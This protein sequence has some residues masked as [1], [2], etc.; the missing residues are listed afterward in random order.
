MREV[1]ILVVEHHPITRWGLVTLIKG[2]RGWEVCGEAPTGQSAIQ[3][4]ASLQPNVIVLDPGLPDMSG[5]EVIPKIL[6]VDPQA[7]ILAITEHESAEIPS[8]LLNVG[9]RGVVLKSDSLHEIV[10]GVRSVSFGRHFRSR[11]AAKLIDSG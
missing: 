3:T 9:A 7:N 6:Q 2:Q 4:V 8:D 5:F 10:E 11:Q 1:S